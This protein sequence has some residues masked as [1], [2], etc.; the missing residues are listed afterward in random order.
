LNVKGK[1]YRFK[2]KKFKRSNWKKAYILLK[3]GYKI[4][5]GGNV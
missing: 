2:Y 5:F 1:P 3:P 4:N